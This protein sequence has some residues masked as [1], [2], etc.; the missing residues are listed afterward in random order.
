MY[1]KMAEK[2]RDMFL[3]NPSVKGEGGGGPLFGHSATNIL[4]SECVVR[5]LAVRKCE[6]IMEDRAFCNLDLDG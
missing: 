6:L 4:L 2:L 1:Q 5:Y 3:R